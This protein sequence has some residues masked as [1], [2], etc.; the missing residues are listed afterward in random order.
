VDTIALNPGI[1]KVCS[2]DA[3]FLGA[4]FRDEGCYDKAVL[5]AEMLEHR[6]E[7]SSKELVEIVRRANA[8]LAILPGHDHGA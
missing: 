8:M 1:L 5:A 7:L 4:H 3:Y 6:R 2:A